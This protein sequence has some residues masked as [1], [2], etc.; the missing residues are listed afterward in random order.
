MASV[1]T[2]GR[3]RNNGRFFI[4]LKPRDERTRDADQIIT[5]CARSS[6]RSRAPL[7]LQAAQ[8]INVGGRTARTQYQYTLQDANIDE[9]NDWAPKMLA[10]LQTLPSCATSPPT[11]RPTPAAR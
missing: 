3:Q 8:D 11:S 1:G 5:G 9:L 10:K 4:T 7:F 2:G 6:P